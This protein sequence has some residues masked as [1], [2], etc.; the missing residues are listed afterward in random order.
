MLRPSRW[1][2]P[3]EATSPQDRARWHAAQLVALTSERMVFRIALIGD[4]Q[5]RD[6]RRGTARLEIFGCDATRIQ[7]L[8]LV[9][10][11][12]IRREVGERIKELCGTIFLLSDDL[13]S[14]L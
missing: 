12:E 8:V 6:I 7:E 13:S 1:R 9:R 3:A 5:L 11:R 14:L 4:E 10:A 2:S